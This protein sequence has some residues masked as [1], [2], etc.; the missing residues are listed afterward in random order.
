MTR[1]RQ[2]DASAARPTITVEPEPADVVR[3]AVLTGLRAFNRRHAEAPEFEPLVL[4]ARDATG[5]IV[6]GLVGMVG[7][8]WLHLDLLWV[9]DTHR[10]MG[11]GTNLLRAAENEAALRGARHVDLDTFDFQAKPFYEREG[12]SVFGILEDYPPGHTRY[13]MRKDLPEPRGI[14]A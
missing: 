2:P 13:F 9:D 3:E 11:V 7:W 4:A 8:K 14:G 5:T 10:G 1:I 12:Y 6:G